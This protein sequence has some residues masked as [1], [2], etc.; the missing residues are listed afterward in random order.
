MCLQAAPRATRV[1]EVEA[2]CLDPIDARGEPHAQGVRVAR[3]AL[4]G[5]RR[6]Q[7]A[8]AG[9]Q[10]GTQVLLADEE[11]F[12]SPLE[13]D[14]ALGGGEAEVVEGAQRLLEDGVG[15][16]RHPSPRVAAPLRHAVP[17]APQERGVDRLDLLLHLLRVGER[18][19]R[20]LPLM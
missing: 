17:V 14:E 1:L 3:R 10:G 13:H 9:A 7:L 15:Q 4:V 18:V 11:P 20:R 16:Q 8:R 6:R 5:E 19:L 2:D 12:G